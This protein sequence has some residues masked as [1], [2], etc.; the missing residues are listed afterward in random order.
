MKKQCVLPIPFCRNRF[1]QLLTP[2]L[3]YHL[4]VTEPIGETGLEK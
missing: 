4:D 3:D 2:G 1:E